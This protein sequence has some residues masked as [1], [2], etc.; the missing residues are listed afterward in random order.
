M[1]I[2]LQN[3]HLC[4]KGISVGVFDG[5]ISGCVNGHISGRVSGVIRYQQSTASVVPQL[6]AERC[7]DLY[8]PGPLSTQSLTKTVSDYLETSSRL[9]GEE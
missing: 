4:V 2:T 9:A 3:G 7:I 1:V 8:Q 5:Y 6:L